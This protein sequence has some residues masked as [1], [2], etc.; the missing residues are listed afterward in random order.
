MDT[1]LDTISR[2]VEQL[3]GRASGPLHFRLFVMPIVVTILA[4]RAH[5]RDVREGHPIYLGAFFTSPT[6]RR[7]LLRSGLEDFGRV[8]IIACVLDTTYQILVLRA[9]Y[10]VQMLIVAV[11]CAIVPYFL[12]RGPVTRLVYALRRRGAADPTVA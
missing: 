6:E 9:F 3:L 5:L 8:F 10:P 11:A 2:S 1:F 12:I 7:R 4:I